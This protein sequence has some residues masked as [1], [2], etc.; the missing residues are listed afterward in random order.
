MLSNKTKAKIVY[1]FR[2]FLKTLPYHLIVMGSVLIVSIIFNKYVEALCFL[3]AFFSLRYKFDTTYHAKSIFIC[4]PLTILIFTFSITI[5]PPVCSYL[6]MSI[7]FAYIDCLLLWLI[8]SRLD[9]LEVIKMYSHKT[10]WEMNEQELSEYLW[11][12]NIR[13][14]RLEFV[15]MVIIYNMKFED[16]A[17]KLKYS[18]ETLKDWSSICK[19]KLG[20]KSWKQ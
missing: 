18:V 16:I 19:K 7:L 3:T 20:I 11:A 8:Q 17:L 1:R 14:D 12:K 9:G 10:I 15:V 5:C 4:I 6:L 2:S 13:G